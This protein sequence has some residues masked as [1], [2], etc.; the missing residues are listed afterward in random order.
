MNTNDQSPPPQRRPLRRLLLNVLAVL[1][2]VPVTVLAGATPASADTS[3]FRGANWAVLGD[4]FVEGPLVLDGL[5]SSDSYDTVYAK[6][7]AIYDDMETLLGAN[8]VRLPVNT[9]TV[10]S[11]WWNAYR[12]TIDAATDRGFKVVLA[13]WEDGAASG[14]RITDMAAF[15]TMWS[16]VTSQYGSNGLVYFEPMN[17]PHGYSSQEWRDLAADWLDYHY[18]APPGR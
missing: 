12:A 5:N 18:S 1:A 17:E 16:T 8:T 15:N 13:Y 7:D 2:L 4:N 11:A 9:H 6:A 14:G 10:G 3:D